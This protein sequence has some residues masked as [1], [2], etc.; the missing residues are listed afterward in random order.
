MAEVG[1]LL[2]GAPGLW[3]LSG[4][5]ALDLWLGR[6]T[7]EHGDIDVS[8]WRRDWPGLLAHAMGSLEVFAAQDGG[9]SPVSD[10]SA[11]TTAHNFWARRSGS[12]SWALQLNIEEGTD[13]EWVYRRDPGIRLPWSRAVLHDRELPYVNPAVQLLFKTKNPAAKDL[14]DLSLFRPLLP[15]QDAAWL[16]AALS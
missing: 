9:L 6:T 3:W 15:E 16:S 13:D 14:A 4:G 5:Q 8:V 2:T 10:A 11:P 12:T 1:A 7:R